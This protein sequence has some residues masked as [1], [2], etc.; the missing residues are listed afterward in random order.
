MDVK[1]QSVFWLI[2]IGATLSASKY[3]IC[4]HNKEIREQHAFGL[5][6]ED[7]KVQQGIWHK[8]PCLA[9]RPGEELDGII[10]YKGSRIDDLG[11][12]RLISRKGA[13]YFPTTERYAFSSDESSLLIK[14]VEKTDE[15]TYL[16][17]VI[18]ENSLF[19]AKGVHINVIADSFPAVISDTSTSARLDQRSRQ[20]LPCQ[21]AEQVT[22]GISVVYWSAGNGVIADTEIIGA[23]FSDGTFIQTKYGTDCNI[24]PDAS[25]IVNCPR[26]FADVTRLWCHVFLSNGTQR[27]CHTDLSFAAPPQQTFVLSRSFAWLKTILLVHVTLLRL[28][29]GLVKQKHSRQAR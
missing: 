20:L 26:A 3:H 2:I 29:A 27:N 24:D 25:L 5:L 12:Q 7:A 28:L 4:P 19:R 16:C 1:K 22:E 6:S 11:T 15:G 13:D 9:Y 10:W 18:P 23:R 21:C 14:G 8:I 17:Q